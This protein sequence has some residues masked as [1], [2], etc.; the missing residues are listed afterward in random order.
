MRATPEGLVQQPVSGRSQEPAKSRAQ[1]RLRAQ[2]SSAVLMG[3]D[4]HCPVTEPGQV[5]LSDP[6]HVVSSTL[7]VPVALDASISHLFVQFNRLQTRPW[8]ARCHQP[9]CA[10][11]LGFQ[12]HPAA[13]GFQSFDWV[14]TALL[15]SLLNPEN[16]SWTS[17]PALQASPGYFWSTQ[18][19]RGA[20][21]FY[22][23]KGKVSKEM[24]V[25][26][27]VQEHPK[28]LDIS[29]ELF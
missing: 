2:P 4:W 7:S 26:F 24:E 12:T 14:W 5:L 10:G 13:R 29:L 17:E 15:F 6:S 1:P 16:Y 22:S 9:K 18:P 19:M 23:E 8:V 25:R 27:A 28:N 21:K 11:R 3:R 20:V